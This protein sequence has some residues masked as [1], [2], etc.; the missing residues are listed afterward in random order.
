ML[1]IN[2][3]RNS[4][5]NNLV[6]SRNYSSSI[7]ARSIEEKIKILIL[8]DLLRLDWN[9]DFDTNMVNLTPPESYD[10]NIIRASMEFKRQE[11]IHKNLNWLSSHFHVA[12]ENL[13]KGIDAF[14]SKID[15]IIEVCETKKQLDLFR[16][17]RFYWSSPYSD[18]VGRRIKLLIRDN[19]LP[20]KPLIGIAALGSSIIHIPDRDNWIGWDTK[21]RTENLVYT[22][23]AYVLG[24]MPPYSYLLGGKLISYILASNE[25]R[26]IYSHKYKN[27]ITN[28]SQRKANRLACLFTTSLFGKSSQYNRIRFN[29]QLLYIPIGKTMG[30]GTLHLT[31]ETFDAMRELIKSKNIHVSNRFGDGPIWRIRVIRTAADLLGFDADFLLKHSFRRNIY[32]I[33][34]AENYQNFLQGKHSRLK[35]YDRPMNDLVRYWR[36][37]WLDQRKNNSD[38]KSKILAFDPKQ[39]TI[40]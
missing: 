34:L 11:I 1:S 3:K 19:S 15:P 31:D 37:R 18:Y 2:I 13:A 40:Y 4:A 32:V 10:K 25:I 39:F 26:N 9:I 14:N 20:N 6:Y 28:I 5:F 16:I 12:R 23:D 17:C 7:E 22:M 27:T 8:R 24:A 38:I 30:Y 36:C 35:Y 29:E 33:P 21:A